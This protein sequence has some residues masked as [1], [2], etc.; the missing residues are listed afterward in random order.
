MISRKQNTDFGIVLSLGLLVGALLCS[1]DELCKAAV[2]TLLATALCPRAYTPLSYLWYGLAGLCERFF[3]AILLA[4]VF[5]LLVT[6][7]GL[8]RRSFTRQA[9][10]GQGRE[11]VFVVKD[12]VYEAGDLL[13]QY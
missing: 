12:K 11:S 10:F 1:R 8:V 5:Y 9:R 2:V 6:P 7:V 13:C 3:S 4:A